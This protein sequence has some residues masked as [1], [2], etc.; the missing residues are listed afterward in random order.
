MN[1]LL[2]LVVVGLTVGGIAPF[3]VAS[4][5]GTLTGNSDPTASAAVGID[6]TYLDV[7]IRPST[8]S[9]FSNESLVFAVR[10]ENPDSRNEN[11]TGPV[12]VSTE[13]NAVRIEPL[14][15]DKLFAVPMPVQRQFPDFTWG[16]IVELEPGE[17]EWIP[18]RVELTSETGEYDVTASAYDL[19]PLYQVEEAGKDRTRIDVPCLVE[20][21]RE[22]RIVYLMNH[23][24]EI[25]GLIVGI[26]G[27][28]LAFPRVQARLRKSA[29]E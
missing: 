19:N 12:T 4:P 28:L 24:Y 7:E 22:Q 21:E 8:P 26:A 6:H 29:T 14:E 25:V 9:A 16:R 11:F 1:K 13:S 27:L 18:V 10:V 15:R 23:L 17:S 20:C 3:A 5:D 2:A